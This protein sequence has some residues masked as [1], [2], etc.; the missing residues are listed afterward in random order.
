MSYTSIESGLVNIIIASM[1]AFDS[2]NTKAG[3]TDAAFSY[4]LSKG[5]SSCCVVDYAGFR[6]DVASA[7][8]SQ[9]VIWSL[10]VTFYIE[11]NKENI[12]TDIRSIVDDFTPL[13]AQN[14]TLG[15]TTP[16]ASLAAGDAFAAITRQQKVYVPVAFLIEAKEQLT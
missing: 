16:G 4:I 14:H 11:F 2:N 6:R 1:S 12:E 15:S 7:F 3:E 9:Q 8:L 13:I 5:L 10:R